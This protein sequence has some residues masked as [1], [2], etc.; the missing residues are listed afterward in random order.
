MRGLCRHT[1]LTL[2][3]GYCVTIHAEADQSAVRN[4]EYVYD[5]VNRLVSKYSE[6]QATEREY[7]QLTVDEWSRYQELMEKS[8]WA[9]WQHNASP[10]AILSHYADSLA[11]KRRYARIEAELDQWRQH[12]S[13]QFQT[14][15]DQERAVVSARYNASIGGRLPILDNI[16]PNDQLQMYVKGGTCDARCRA[17]VGR[18][19]ERNARVD[20]YVTKAPTEQDIF[21]WAESA[22][23][24]VDRVQV[25]QITLNHGA[26]LVN[27]VAREVGITDPKLPLLLVRRGK[28]LQ[29]VLL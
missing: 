7:W 24:P 19:L 29:E 12:V 18:V 1:L 20:I 5:D 11:E 13:V 15:Y 21:R 16:Q 26:G 10:L 28:S 14:L 3:V 8:P 4:T 23:I 6:P 25:R 27:A 2:V 9:T 17:V 22:A